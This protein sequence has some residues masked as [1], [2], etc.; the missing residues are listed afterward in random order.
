[1]LF[2][3][4]VC[5]R[6]LEILLAPDAIGSVGYPPHHIGVVGAPPSAAPLS[7]ATPSAK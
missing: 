6:A 2:C 4:E 1:M 3:C 7:A 5:E